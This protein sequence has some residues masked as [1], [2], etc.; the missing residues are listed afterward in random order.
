MINKKKASIVSELL[1]LVIAGYFLYNS[2]F[3]LKWQKQWYR[4]GS[5]FP[6]IISVVV[7]GAAL[8]GLYQDLFGANKGSKKTF[9]IGSLKRLPIILGIMVL[10]LIV[11]QMLGYFYLSMFVGTAVMIAMMN[12]LEKNWTKRI[13]FAV[14]I[15]GVFIGFV[16]VLFD[17]ICQI[18]M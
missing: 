16:Y 4:S 7:I 17:M 18:S 11:W 8:A 15:S 1:I 13:G 9:S 2:L 14:V 6:A 10:E 3:V 5:L 12:V